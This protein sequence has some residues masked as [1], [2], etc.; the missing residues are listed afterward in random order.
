[1]ADKPNNCKIVLLGESGVGKTCIISR[2]VN[3]TYDDKSESTNGAS[4][5]SKTIEIQGKNLRFDIW[6]TAG[7]EKYRSLTKF[8]YKDATIAILVYDITRKQSFEEWKNYWYD[9]LKTCGEKNVVGIAG[10][11]CDK[12]D[13]EEVSETEAKEFASSVDAVF[14]LTSAFKNSGIDELFNKVGS[15]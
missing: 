6:D 8:F 9:Q 13:E 1:M 10:N 4:Y 5:A 2:Y 15:K 3:G 11:K 12:F 7:Q 14:G